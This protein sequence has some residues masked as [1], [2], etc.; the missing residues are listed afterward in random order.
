MSFELFKVTKKG[1]TINTHE[2]LMHPPFLTIYKRDTSATKGI[3]LKEFFYIY[4]TINIKSSLVNKGYSPKVLSKKAIKHIHMPDGWQPDDSIVI[5]SKLY[6]YLTEGMQG[7]N[8]KSILR[9]FNNSDVI[10]NKMNDTL[11]EFILKDELTKVEIADASHTLK[12]LMTLATS[13]PATIEKLNQSKKLAS[14]ESEDIR[15]ARG[16]ADITSSMEPR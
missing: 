10:I 13:I 15:T 12:D 5:A 9:T 3:A 4:M 14:D 8:F 1:L 16:G 6:S 11:E 2:V 7:R